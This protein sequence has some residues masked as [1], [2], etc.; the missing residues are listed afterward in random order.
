MILS[1][2]STPTCKQLHQRVERYVFY[3]RPHLTVNVKKGMEN[4]VFLTSAGNQL[5]NLAKR[6]ETIGNALGF[7]V[8]S[9]SEVRR[10]VATHAANTLEPREQEVVR[11]QMKHSNQ[12]QEKHYVCVQSRQ[13]HMLSCTRAQVLTPH[14]RVVV[15]VLSRDEERSQRRK[16]TLSSCSFKLR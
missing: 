9:P 6:A 4:L 2:I 16:R 13:Q 7:K 14:R 3:L 11:K 12:V 8:F 10:V 1:A 5:C 15:L